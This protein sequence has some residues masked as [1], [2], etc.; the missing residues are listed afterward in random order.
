MLQARSPFWGAR[1]KIG[2]SHHRHRPGRYDVFP[3][4]RANLVTSLCMLRSSLFV[5]QLNSVPSMQTRCRMTAGFREPAALALRR[6][7]R[8]VSL[9]LQ[10]FSSDHFGTR[11]SST[12]AASNSYGQLVDQA[13]LFVGVTNLPL[14]KPY[15]V[16]FTIQT[17]KAGL[18]YRLQD[19]NMN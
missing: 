3:P 12:P 13:S 16:G 11:V 5:D 1:R 2:R 8:L 17:V 15:S 14:P 4:C 6:P 7:F 9:A 19:S 10:A 18:N